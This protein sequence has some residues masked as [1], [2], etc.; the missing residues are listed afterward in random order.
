MGGPETAAGFYWYCCKQ[1]HFMHTFAVLATLVNEK[2]TPLPNPSAPFFPYQN[3]PG[4]V[5][6]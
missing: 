5:T 3:L 4:H 2:Q 6:L 1:F